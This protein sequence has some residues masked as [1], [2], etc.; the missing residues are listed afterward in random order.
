[1]GLEPKLGQVLCLVHVCI[2][3]NELQLDLP[4]I[5]LSTVVSKYIDETEKNLRRVSDAVEEEEDLLFLM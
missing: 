3:A 5:D 2:E 1:M 4:S